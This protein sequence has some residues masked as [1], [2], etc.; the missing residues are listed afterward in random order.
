[1]ESFRAEHIVRSHAFTVAMPIAHAYELFMPEGERAWA[2]GWE[3]TYLHP[4][5][6]FPGRGM[7][8]TT[9]HGGEYTLWTMTRHEPTSG[10]VEYQR[11]TPGSRMGSVLVE[12]AA[13]DLTRTRVSVTYALT[14]L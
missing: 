10:I 2:P 1:M 11:I 9:G 3:P 14:G 4:R 7:V 12:C 13:K 8:F 6:G 5:D